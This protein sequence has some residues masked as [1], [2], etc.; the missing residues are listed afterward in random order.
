M[1]NVDNIIKKLWDIEDE[2]DGTYSSINS[3]EIRY[4]CDEVRKVLI[5]Q[6]MLLELR[7]PMTICGDIHGQFHDLLRIFRLAGQPPQENYTFL[8]DYVDRGLNSIE[9]VCLVFAYKIKYPENFFILRGN[10]ESAPTNEYFGFLEECETRFSIDIWKLF[11][12][13]FNYLPLVAIIED[14][15][16]CVHGGISPY[17]DSLDQIKSIERPYEVPES[18]I[19]CDLLWS[20]P[21]CDAG[22]WEE[23]SRGTSFVFGSNPLQNFL[24]KFNL[25]LIIRGHQAVSCGYDFTF[26]DIHG[27]VTVFSAP[28]YCYQYQN[29]GAILHIDKHLVPSF[30]VLQPVDTDSN[31]YIGPRPGTPPVED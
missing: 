22:S 30:S 9:T 25:E 11:C 21:D 6:P 10:H 17:I 27:I 26:P 2:P 8:G 5:D 12:D 23:N 19:I 1:F 14:K 28:N 29:K 16:F 31:Y 4:L 15:Y 13:T 3:A 7:A 18:G 20:D 24:K